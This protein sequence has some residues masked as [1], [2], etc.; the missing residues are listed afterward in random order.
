M[1]PISQEKSPANILAQIE[2]LEIDEENGGGFKGYG[3]DHM[4]THISGLTRLP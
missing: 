4:W 3:T 1:G 2:A